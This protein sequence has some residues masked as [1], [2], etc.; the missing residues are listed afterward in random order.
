M[1]YLT[2]QDIYFRNIVDQQHMLILD[3]CKMQKKLNAKYSVGNLGVYHE[4]LNEL[5]CL[6]RRHYN[7][8]EKWLKANESPGY[9]CYVDD[10][11]QYELL[12]QAYLEAAMAGIDLREECAACTLTWWTEHVSMHEVR[13]IN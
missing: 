13:Y 5:C 7:F 2:S 3:L 9:E 6:S 8:E 11:C 1:K 12:L 4:W 10:Y